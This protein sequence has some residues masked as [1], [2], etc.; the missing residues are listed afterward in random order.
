[1]GGGLLGGAVFA[2]GVGVSPGLVGT[3][4]DMFAPFPC[5]AHVC[6]SLFFLV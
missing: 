4:M 5:I 1:M 3:S 6:F 2:V